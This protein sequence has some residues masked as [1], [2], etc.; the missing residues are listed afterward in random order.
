MLAN[1]STADA[2]PTAKTAATSVSRDLMNRL[3]ACSAA[4][5]RGRKLA[6]Q[7]GSCTLSADGSRG[8][9]DAPDFT[10]R[11]ENGAEVS[12]ASLRGS[13][14][15]LIF[16]HSAFSAMCTK[17]LHQT[18]ELADRYGDAGAEVFGISVDSPSC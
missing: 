9:Q 10:L 5:K 6:S 2:A 8:G 14:V 11:D 4:A 3:S 12:L 1:A 7:T 13:N 17:E 18:T 16:F 15:V